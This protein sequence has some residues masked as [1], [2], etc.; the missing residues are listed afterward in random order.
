MNELLTGF[1]MVT[2]PHCG[3]ESQWDDYYNLKAGD[4]RECDKC[5]EQIHILDV[6]YMMYARVHTHANGGLVSEEG[7]SHAE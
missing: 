3:V 4:H 5:G 7:L 6:E 2:C 1:P